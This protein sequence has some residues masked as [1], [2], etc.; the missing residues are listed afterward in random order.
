MLFVCQIIDANDDV[1]E[2]EEK[3]TMVQLHVGGLHCILVPSHITSY[4]YTF[5]I[6]ILNLRTI[7]HAACRS[8]VFVGSGVALFLEGGN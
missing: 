6:H 4:D 3:R 8:F 2:E 7:A 1:E 5:T